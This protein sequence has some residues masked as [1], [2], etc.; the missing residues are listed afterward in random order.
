MESFVARQPIFNRKKQIIAFELLFRDGTGNAMPDIDGDTAS[1]QL[2]T[3]SYLGI[4]MEALTEGKRA[5]VNFTENLLLKKTPLLFPKETTVVEVLETVTP[6]AAVVAA[7]QEI[8]RQGYMIALDDFLYE[9]TWKPLI[10]L[11]RIIKIDFRLTPTEE[12]REYIEKLQD[13]NL[14]FLAEKV[15]TYEEFRL[16]EEMGFDLFQGYF[17]CRPEVIRGKEIQGQ[18]VSLLQIMAESGK[19][20][21]DIDRMES[22]IHRDVGIA[23]KLLRYMNSAFFRRIHE[24]ASIRQAL[25]MLGTEEIRRFIALIAMTNLSTDKPEALVKTS[26]I[27][28]KFCERLGAA[29]GHAGITSELFTLGMFSLLDALLDEPME[30][31][32]DALPLS[33]SLVEALLEH[34]GPLIPYLDLAIAYERGDWEQV[35]KAIATLKISENEIPGLYLDACEWSQ[36]AACI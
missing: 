2:L 24:I 31:I 7:C 15:E 17:F 16:A 22:L 11:A 4:G 27:R 18:H 30:R 10:D 33:Q 32:L 8:A 26:C 28:G 12:I 19:A 25:I 35:P 23:Y 9:D 14:V 1:S 3:N 34:K 6:S 21:M 29:A 20:D 13:Q 36:V 5:F